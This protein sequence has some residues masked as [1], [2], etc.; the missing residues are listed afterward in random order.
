MDNN[1]A[2]TDYTITQRRVQFQF[3]H[4]LLYLTVRHIALE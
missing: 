3:C 4:L 2:Y 1:S